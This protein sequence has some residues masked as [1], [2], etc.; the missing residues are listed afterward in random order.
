[1]SD[2]S[3]GNPSTSVESLSMNKFKDENGILK[4]T[5]QAVSYIIAHIDW[6]INKRKKVSAVR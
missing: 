1:M 2:C 3:K 6:I 5:L 4:K